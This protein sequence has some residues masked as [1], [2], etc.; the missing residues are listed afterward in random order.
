MTDF[1]VFDG[2]NDLILRLLRGEV[3]ATG[4]AAELGEAGEIGGDPEGEGTA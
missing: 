4:G 3:D 2:H 1:P